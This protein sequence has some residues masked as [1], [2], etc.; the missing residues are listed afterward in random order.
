MTTWCLSINYIFNKLYFQ[1]YYLTLITKWFILDFERAKFSLETC[2]LHVHVFSMYMYCLT[3]LFFRFYYTLHTES[4]KL[5][6]QKLPSREKYHP[7]YNFYIFIY[8]TNSKQFSSSI[9]KKRPHNFRRSCLILKG[10][11]W[12]RSFDIFKF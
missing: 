1:H 10:S 9:F 7:A 3:D 6:I 2:I 12:P 11:V 8:I 5:Q 4:Y